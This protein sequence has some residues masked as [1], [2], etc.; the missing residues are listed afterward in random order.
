MKT[1]LF[2]PLSP[3]RTPLG[4]AV[5]D[6]IHEYRGSMFTDQPLADPAISG[7][8]ALVH[9]GTLRAGSSEETNS[10]A[11]VQRDASK[12]PSTPTT[13]LI[14]PAPPPRTSGRASR[15]ARHRSLHRAVKVPGQGRCGL[16]CDARYCDPAFLD[17]DVSA[18]DARPIRRQPSTT[19]LASRC[20]GELVVAVKEL[21]DPSTATISR[22][23]SPNV[24]VF[25][26]FTPE[27]KAH[28]RL[29]RVQRLA[30]SNARRP[31]ALFRHN[32]PPPAVSERRR[33]NAMTI[34]H[35]IKVFAPGNAAGIT[36]MTTAPCQN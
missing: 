27:L 4:E 6:L 35:L 21:L 25:H 36:P 11:C 13:I 28:V 2:D 22:T 1:M 17:H 14:H 31:P 29:R 30:R 32:G 26:E 34:V 16:L 9:I 8:L 23:E 12:R 18:A 10:A 19:V 7:P 24:E 3:T 20:M 15:H 33:V 5:T